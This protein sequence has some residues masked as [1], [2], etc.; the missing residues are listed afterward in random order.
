MSF[1]VVEL[2]VLVSTQAREPDSNGD[3]LVSV[4]KK[5]RQGCP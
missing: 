5:A 4:G 1:Q 2:I 3:C